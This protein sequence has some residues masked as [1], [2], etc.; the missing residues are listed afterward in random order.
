M[1]KP[2]DQSD[3]L[4][5]IS[6]L[7]LLIEAGRKAAVHY[8]NTALTGTY[9]LMGRRIVEYEQKGKKR[10]AYG[11]ATL[12]RLSDDLTQRFGKGFSLARLKNV[13]LFYLTYPE[14]SYTLSSQLNEVEKG[15]T[16]SGQSAPLHGGGSLFRGRTI[17]Y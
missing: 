2:A 13:R 6:D 12:Q 4:S 14:K 11:E 15:Q 3:Y 8:V 10:A 1:T 17:V 7:A 5:L 16:P 9:W